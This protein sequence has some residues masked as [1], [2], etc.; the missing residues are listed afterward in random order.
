MERSDYP[1]I[2]S[3]LR[4]V[5]LMDCE[6]VGVRLLRSAEELS[7][8]QWPRPETPL[9]YCAAIRN[10]VGGARHILTA[11]DISCNTSPRTLGLEPGFHDP[12]FVE[13]YVT[14]ALYRDTEVAGEILGEVPVLEGVAGV[15]VAP[16]SSFDE[17]IPP[18][19]VVLP[20]SPY[21]AMRVTQAAAFNGHRV[22]NSTLGM[23][24]IC[25][26]STAAPIVNGT[27][28]L[29]LLCSG[30]RHAAGWSDT[31]MSM[32]VPVALLSEL[33]DGLVRTAQRFETDERKRR[34][35]QGYRSH[36]PQEGT[37]AET[38]FALEPGRAY[39]CASR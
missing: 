15:A 30:T 1:G 5:L 24:G 6:P 38:I 14:G 34:I 12:D 4:A 33:V 35:A 25:A 36:V 9:A 27:I 20:L 7:A 28:S 17:S 10:A 22:M 32:G 29:S 37:V 11:A 13:S 2:A 16:L 39:F 21:A 23:H 3:V 8:C 31:A 18:D 26:E 19:V